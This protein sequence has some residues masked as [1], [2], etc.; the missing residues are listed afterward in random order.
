MNEE[1]IKK[2][3]NFWQKKL[4]P[5]FNFNTKSIKF[6]ENRVKKKKYLVRFLCHSLS[7]S[8]VLKYFLQSFYLQKISIFTTRHLFCFPLTSPY[9][10][11]P[12]LVLFSPNLSLFYP[13]F[14][15]LFSPNLSSFRPS[16]TCLQASD[17]QRRYWTTVKSDEVVQHASVRPLPQLLP[18]PLPQTLPQSL[19][20][21][22][23][24]LL[25]QPQPQSL[26]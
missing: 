19:S 10:V 4:K 17:I 18:P 9:F 22:L 25:L 6:S 1:K 12:S 20:Q 15:V 2:N 11:S 8:L 5:W 23:S 24:Q 16:N 14:I 13:S 3:L 21:P 26:V 7:H